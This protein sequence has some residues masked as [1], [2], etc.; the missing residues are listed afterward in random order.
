MGALGAP[1]NREKRRKNGRFSPK[2]EF[3]GAPA[4]PKSPTIRPENRRFWPSF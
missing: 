1:E 4:R 3:L 2:L